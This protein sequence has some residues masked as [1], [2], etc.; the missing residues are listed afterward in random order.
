ML[1]RAIYSVSLFLVENQRYAVDHDLMYWRKKGILLLIPANRTHSSYCLPDLLGIWLPCKWVF[2][3][4][5]HWIW[6]HLRADWLRNLRCT[7]YLKAIQ[8]V[9][10]CGKAVLF[11]LS[12]TAKLSLFYVD[13]SFHLPNIQLYYWAFI[14]VIFIAV[15]D[16]NSAGKIVKQFLYQIKYGHAQNDS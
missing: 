4:I 11:Q 14:L 16:Q 15:T 10:C 12:F 13:G 6:C 8:N 1:I 7:V 9:I 5:Q 2:E 3:V